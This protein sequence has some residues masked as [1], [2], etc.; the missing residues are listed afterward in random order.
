MRLRAKSKRAEASHS[1]RLEEVEEAEEAIRTLMFTPTQ[2]ARP[3]KEIE[4][5]IKKE[6]MAREEVDEV[7]AAEADEEGETEAMETEADEEVTITKS[8]STR[9]PEAIEK[10]ERTMAG[11]KRILTLRRKELRAT[12]RSLISLSE[13]E[14]KSTMTQEAT[15]SSMT[16]ILTS[17]GRS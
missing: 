3:I 11:A 4:K 14:R 17:L 7:E 1:S 5:T 8:S 16:M 2:R 15:E 10:R 12:E 13:V 6:A 9:R